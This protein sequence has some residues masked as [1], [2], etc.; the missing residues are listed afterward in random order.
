MIKSEM[1]Q[2]AAFTQDAWFEGKPEFAPFYMALNLLNHYS[3][4]GEQ[5]LLKTL[6]EKDPQ[7]KMFEVVVRIDI[8]GYVHEICSQMCI[9]KKE[10]KFLEPEAVFNALLSLS[11]DKESVNSILNDEYNGIKIDSPKSPFKKYEVKITF[12]YFEIDN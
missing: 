11:E 10:P 6:Q 8:D 3:P 2:V 5:S 12:S 4:G 7:H 9:Y 1:K